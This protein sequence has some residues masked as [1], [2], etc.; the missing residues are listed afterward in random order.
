MSKT[1]RIRK[2]LDIKL[3]GKAELSVGAG[4]VAAN[5]AI[6]PSDFPGLTP[7][8]SV[9]ADDMVKVGTPLFYDKSQ[10]D[11]KFTSP[12]S[13]KVVA[14]NRGERRRILEVEIESDGKFQ[15]EDFSTGTKS[16]DRETIKQV[17]LK[18][19]LWPYIIQRPFGVIAKA[20][21]TPRDIFISGFDSSPLAP[22]Y[23]FTLSKELAVL[24]AGIDALAKLTDGKV[25]L[26]LR[27]GSK[28]SNLKGVEINFFDGP[29]PAGNVGIQIHKIKPINKGEVLWTVDLQ[30]LVFI[31][32]LFSTGK[33]N[34]EKL[35]AVV[36]SEVVAPQYFKTVVGAMVESLVANKTAKTTTER[37]ISG[38]VL[39][40]TRLDNDGYLGFYNNQVT[41]I[42][43]GNTIEPFGW[44]L[45]GFNK[46]SAGKA[47]LSK[48]FPKKEYVMDANL[49]GG[50]RAFVV[51]EQ[52]E[53]VL[54]MDIL[55]VYLLKSIITND[56][57][58]M[59]Q[60]GI[61]EVIEE[62][63]ALCE[64]ACTSKIEVQDILRGGISTMIKELA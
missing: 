27:Q 28:F 59:E 32:R 8:L 2:G 33:L 26:G 63:M 53:K 25:Y 43:E 31:G 47:F 34:M 21:D 6:K 22:D 13:G 46:F 51:S 19:G 62:D 52:Y 48:L 24:Q 3:K 16:P 38:N 58:K 18:S 29:H 61:Y 17:L 23:E 41:V 55:P 42:P 11:V 56:I 9:K 36:G 12:V 44:A 5:F 30:A 4:N 20:L 50:E 14:I 45:P 40:G 60:L 35:V 64:F 15:S 7:K 54:P 37:I 10:P 39:T 57:D 1:I 49:H